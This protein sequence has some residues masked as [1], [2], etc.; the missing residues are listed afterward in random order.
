MS[1]PGVVIRRSLITCPDT[2]LL[3]LDD[4]TSFNQAPLLIE[5]SEFDC[6]GTHGSGIAE[7]NFTARRVDIHGCENGFSL[8]QN[9]V[10]E[11]SYIHD[12]YN[13]DGAHMDGVQ[14]AQGHWNGSGYVCCALNITVSHNRIE[15]I[16][17]DGDYGSSAMTSNR[18]PDVNILIENNLLAYGSYTLYCVQGATGVNYR[19]VDNRFVPGAFGFST[20]CSDEV[21]SGNVNHATGQPIA[22]D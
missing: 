4:N 15:A 12:L 19:V 16:D 21:Q 3:I 10:I 18:A 22:L 11:D 1:A 20:D 8:N 5:D 17:P 6:Q 14:L 7:A 13:D 9:V 2:T